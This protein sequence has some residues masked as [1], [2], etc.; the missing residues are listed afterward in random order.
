MQNSRNGWPHS[1]VYMYITPFLMLG[2]PHTCNMYDILNQEKSF[3]K[4]LQCFSFHGFFIPQGILFC[5][6]TGHW[7]VLWWD[8]HSSYGKDFKSQWR[9]RTGLTIAFLLFSFLFV[10]VV[11]SSK[12][13][14][15]IIRVHEQSRWTE[16]CSVIGYLGWQGTCS[17]ILAAWDYSFVSYKKTV[18]SI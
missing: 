11:S 1:T 18:F 5:Y 4:M 17:T 6:V 7:H 15:P 12:I 3:S 13:S 10:S 9:T 8:R 2:L 16:S 14:Y